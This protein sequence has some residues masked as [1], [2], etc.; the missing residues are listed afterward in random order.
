M[1]RRIAEAKAR[2]AALVLEKEKEAAAEAERQRHMVD[3]TKVERARR[4]AKEREEARWRATLQER[5]ERDKAKREAARIAAATT[6]AIHA[7]A[8]WQNPKSETTAVSGGA[9]H[10]QEPATTQP[11]PVVHAQPT[12]TTPQYAEEPAS[13][14]AQHEPSRE[15]EE[16][17]VEEEYTEEE[18]AEEDMLSAE[19][20]QGT[21]PPATVL[22]EEAAELQ[23]Q[24][25][26]LQRQLQ[27][28]S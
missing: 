9:N 1:E 26:E 28:G 27:L 5:N 6:T 17:E 7:D 3:E 23:R 2:K 21:Q 16:Y 25:D 4:L 8:A 15:E 12:A 20:G 14:Y 24:I 13:S 10:R 18:Y 19:A 11:A 22:D